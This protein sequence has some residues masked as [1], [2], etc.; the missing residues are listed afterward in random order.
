MAHITDPKQIAGIIINTHGAINEIRQANSDINISL[1][2]NP[3]KNTNDVLEITRQVT[4]IPTIG[5]TFASYDGIIARYIITKI[6]N[7]NVTGSNM[8]QNSESKNE[9]TVIYESAVETYKELSKYTMDIV[10]KLATKEHID[11]PENKDPHNEIKTTIQ[12]LLQEKLEAINTTQYYE[13]QEAKPK[14]TINTTSPT[15]NNKSARFSLPKT[16]VKFFNKRRAKRSPKNAKKPDRNKK[17][18]TK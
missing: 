18:N 15:E 1:E 6:I 17:S 3:N 10:K 4:D 7:Q 11:P 12:R 13:I 16:A 8:L 5:E 14:L 9:E 2:G